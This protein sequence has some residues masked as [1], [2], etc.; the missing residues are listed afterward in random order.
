MNIPKLNACN[1]GFQGN[2]LQGAKKLLYATAAT[3]AILSAVSNTNAQNAP[4][5][6]VGPTRTAPM[7]RYE[8]YK[9]LEL[10]YRQAL[11]QK[12]KEADTFT[13][14]PA[15]TEKYYGE[16]T[17]IDPENL[18]EHYKGNLMSDSIMEGL[19]FFVVGAIVGLFGKKD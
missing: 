19:L 13:Y 7:V 2:K 9:T 4:R 3:A 10:K 11:A 12:A 16:N 5:Y 6:T 8:D 17:Y 15:E 14:T 1:A 18:V